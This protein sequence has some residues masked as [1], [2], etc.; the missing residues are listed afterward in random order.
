[1]SQL[2]TGKPKISYKRTSP[3]LILMALLFL[4]APITAQTLSLIETTVDK[5]YAPQGS[6]ASM[7]YFKFNSIGGDSYINS[8][9]FQNSASKVYLGNKISRAT[10]YRD[11]STAGVQGSFDEGVDTELVSLS[12]D[13]LTK[14]QQTFSVPSEL[15][16]SGNPKGYFI[17][18]TIDSS[19]D[20]AA[21]TSIKLLQANG[22]DIDFGGYD[23]ENAVTI[24]GLRTT[25]ITSILP[26]VVLPGQTKVGALKLSI[27][28]SGENMNKG[29][30]FVVQN[31][32]SNFVTSEDMKNGIVAAYLYKG[33]NGEDTY[34]SEFIDNYTAISEVYAGSFT[35]SNIVTFTF[36]NLNDINLQDGITANLFVVYDI[37]SDFNV[38]DNTKVK[39]QLKS[40]TGTGELSG[41]S[42]ALQSPLPTQAGSAY[43]AG[44]SCNS[45][46]VKSLINPTDV[47]G[48]NSE[49]PIFEF[50]LR[51][52]QVD[53]SLSTINIQNPGNV[54][55]ITTSSDPKNI[56]RIKLYADS[57]RDGVFSPSID[58][59]I[60]NCPL[61]RGYNQTDRAI[62]TLNVLST[63]FIINKFDSDA[64]KATQYLNNNAVRIFT[65]YDFG[66]NISESTPATGYS[67]AYS[68]ARLDNALGTANVSNT[69]YAISLSGT[70]PF[71]ATPEAKVQLSNA[72]DIS[73]LSSTTLTPTFA[74][75][76]QVRVP[77]MLL[78]INSSRT[79]T[80]TNITIK[81]E[82]STFS[83]SNE[84]V[85]KVW[86]Y[87]DSNLNSK[88]DTADTLLGSVSNPSNDTFANI[89]GV[90]IYT[91]K[92]SLIVLYDIGVNASQN[93]QVP[94]IR[95][96]FSNLTASSS[97]AL[98]GQSLPYP[99]SAATLTPSAS[100]LTITNIDY[101]PV[102]N[103]EFTST[104]TLTNPTSTT[105]SVT[106]LEPRLYTSTVSGADISFEF[107]RTPDVAPP[108]SV[109]P[110][111]SFSTNFKCT[112]DN[113]LSDGIA[114][115]DAY[116]QYSVPDSIYP[117][118]NLPGSAELVRYQ[119][120]GTLEPAFTSAQRI[121]ITKKL[122]TTPGQF[123]A[124]IQDTQVIFDTQTQHFGNRDAI[125]KQSAL[126]VTFTNSGQNI[127]ENSIVVRLNGIQ[128]SK[129]LTSL[130]GLSTTGLKSAAFGS[131]TYTTSTGVLTIQDMG[132]SGGT[133]T[134]DVSD[135]QGNPL[136][137]TYIVFSISDIVKIENLYVYPS[138]YLRSP[139]VPLTMGFSLTQPA[140]VKIY[141]YNHVGQLVL[142]E[143]REFTTLGYKTISYDY[144]TSFLNSGMYFCKVYATDVNGNKSNAV[145]K[146][147]IY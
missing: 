45:D 41:G 139:T 47:F 106:Q 61:G 6:K 58:T 77:M 117:I 118:S 56:Q 46:Y 92:N 49:V 55:F 13:G 11:S 71:T 15:I 23:S 7:I 82:S 30:S 102:N 73:I 42:I 142:E 19:A 66:Q 90:P 123:P 26:S 137:T 140:S 133:L 93:S 143:Q 125:P 126:K 101:T 53:I 27:T 22:S 64:D 131:Y 107:N 103:F 130:G 79:F 50:E 3:L 112:H 25:D 14:G 78:S 48:A 21:T 67:G 5:R 20:L 76:G 74:I 8:L 95:A 114:F 59:L 37:G 96:Q 108:Y 136:Q 40:L 29:V 119:S 17:V 68:I 35:S 86:I 1:M 31:S 43:V 115:L 129:S 32:A 44:L 132:S 65:E 134:I 145:T 146:F 80:S 94:N 16:T 116:V 113:A 98:G 105:I 138:P 57:N 10:L 99:A 120:V 60:A 100:R 109:P 88:F 34:N 70:K 128:L 104:I 33:N 2:I 147:A 75:Q 127:D 62:I 141:I 110:N 89:N 36:P 122:T 12:Y 111:G 85:S 63:P 124:Y 83:P 51:A 52:N 18:Y 54:P 24:T 144:N 28:M 91:G 121:N 84:G 72:L 9:T 87:R 97:I 38:T 69:I 39:A 135:L 81:N 4:A